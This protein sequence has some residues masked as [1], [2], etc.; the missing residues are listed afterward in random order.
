MTAVEES[1]SVYQAYPVSRTTGDGRAEIFRAWGPAFEQEGAGQINLCAE[2][3]NPFQGNNLTVVEGMHQFFVY[4]L[5][6]VQPVRRGRSVLRGGRCRR[7]RGFPAA[8]CRIYLGVCY[9]RGASSRRWC[10]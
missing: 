6:V 7:V 8:L 3:V 9:T 10:G 5:Q 1:A 2:T 4:I